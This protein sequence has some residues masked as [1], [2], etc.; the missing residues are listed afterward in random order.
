M[1]CSL[2]FPVSILA[3][4]Q[5]PV[6]AEIKVSLCPRHTLNINN[7]GTLLAHCFVFFFCF[8]V[9][10]VTARC[11]KGVVTLRKNTHIHTHAHR[12]WTSPV[13]TFP[14]FQQAL[15]GFWVVLCQADSTLWKCINGRN[16]NTPAGQQVIAKR[17]LLWHRHCGMT[18]AC[19]LLS[20]SRRTHRAAMAAPWTW[21]VPDKGVIFG[22][23]GGIHPAL[24]NSTESRRV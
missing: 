2:A 9:G 6:A 3:I 17:P 18:N 7:W 23:G 8:L 13:Q 22:E 10:V 12:A 21:S 19:H 1:S 16:S 11:A 24:L 15:C 5:I 4:S 14:P 20:L